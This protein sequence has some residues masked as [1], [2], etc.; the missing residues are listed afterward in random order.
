MSL[1]IHACPRL[2]QL[3]LSP[4]QTK[5]M[6]GNN[7]QGAVYKVYGALG[8]QPDSKF[9]TATAAGFGTSTR[10]IKY[11]GATPG[12]GALLPKAPYFRGVHERHWGNMHDEKVMGSLS[13]SMGHLA[14]SPSG[15]YE[16]KGAIGAQPDSK[17]ETQARTVFGTST[18]DGSVK[19]GCEEELLKTLAFGR[20]SPG[21]C[22]YNAPPGVGKQIASTAVTAPAFKIGTSS[23]FDDKNPTRDVPGAGSYASATPAYGKQV[24]SSKTTLP[25]PKIG[26]S[27]RDST[28]KVRSQNSADWIASEMLLK[29]GRPTVG[30]PN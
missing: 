1:L 20:G 21:P 9:P 11:G 19:L 8:P 18:R 2:S 30:S 26:T 6:S 14:S 15:K 16:T 10:S 13:E 24:L 29:Q 22:T 17:K 3:Y 7:S 23:R 27:T 12:P 5:T 28:K 4:E 25:T